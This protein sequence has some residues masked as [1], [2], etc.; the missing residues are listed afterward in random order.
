LVLTP[1]A[2]CHDHSLP[3]PGSTLC[4]EII[5]AHLS[6]DSSNQL[7]QILANWNEVLKRTSLNQNEPLIAYRKAVVRR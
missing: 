6:A 2:N 3:G 5:L 1:T 7:F 4:D